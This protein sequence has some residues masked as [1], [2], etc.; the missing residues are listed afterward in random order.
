[1]WQRL[2]PCVVE[3]ARALHVGHQP[4]SSIPSNRSPTLVAAAPPLS[5][6]QAILHV[7]HRLKRKGLAYK[8]IFFLQPD[9][10]IE[11][12][13]QATMV[14]VNTMGYMIGS[15]HKAYFDLER[16][17]RAVL[18]LAGASG[19]P[20]RRKYA[21]ELTSRS[22]RLCAASSGCGRAQR[23]EIEEM[24]HEDMHCSHQWYRIFPTRADRPHMAA[25]KKEPKYAKHFT[26]LDRLMFAWLAE[27][28]APKH[29]IDADGSVQVSSSSQGG[30]AARAEPSAGT[31]G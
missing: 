6:R 18:R 2:Q 14:E 16:E 21:A 3:A 19:F 4:Q 29:R 23:L 10:V 24:V 25:L 7:D 11:R 27:G 30:V 31:P 28:W 26:P 8:R 13:G 15:K 22:E 12:D 1:M 20:E 5:P 17:Q 9:V